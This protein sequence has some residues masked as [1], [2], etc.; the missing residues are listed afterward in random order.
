MRRPGA[1]LALL[2][3][4]LVSS[5]ASPWFCE[6][7]GRRLSYVRH[8]ADNGKV[9]WRYTMT[10][11]RVARGSDGASVDYTYDFRKPGGAQ[12]YGGPIEMHARI[13]PAGDV[14]LDIAATM[15]AVFRS[16]FPKA[17]IVSEGGLTVLPAALEPGDSLPDASAVVTVHGMKY[18]VSVTERSVVRRESLK[19]AAGTFDCIVVSEHKVETGPGRNRDVLNYTWYA[20]G[21]GEVRHDTYGWKTRKLETFETLESID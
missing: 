10:F 3:V 5:A 18:T 2:L 9:K 21:V 8:N 14:T 4:S 1:I 20:A 16:M 17:K 12:M 11:D 15:Q 19:T 13:S 7:Q 6:T